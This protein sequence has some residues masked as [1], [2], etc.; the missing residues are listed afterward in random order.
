MARSDPGHLGKHKC[1]RLARIE[2]E[3]QLAGASFFFTARFSSSA[4]G[5]S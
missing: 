4:R 5:D 2:F 3:N 1:A